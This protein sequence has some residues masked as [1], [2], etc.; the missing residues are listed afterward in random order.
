MNT[1]LAFYTDG[2]VNLLKAETMKEAFSRIN[3]EE[4]LHITRVYA[5]ENPGEIVNAFISKTGWKQTD[6]IVKLD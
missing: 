6:T 3:C 4:F 1:Y 5:G 2:S